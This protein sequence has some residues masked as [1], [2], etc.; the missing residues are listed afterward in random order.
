[1]LVIAE[2][3][4]PDWVSVP[5]AG[6]SHWRALSKRV[7]GHLVTHARNRENILKAGEPADRFTT[8]D[9]AAIERSV[10]TITDALRG[11]RGGGLTTVT[12]F[13]A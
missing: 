7:D 5:L 3:A 8:M 13:S 9:T 4:N 1:V 10:Q 12:A 2:L 11:R 6:W